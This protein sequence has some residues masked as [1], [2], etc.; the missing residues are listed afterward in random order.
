MMS[1]VIL[2][3]VLVALLAVAVIVLTA[4]VT[5]AIEVGQKALR[6]SHDQRNEGLMVPT[7]FQKITYA[8]L[9]VLLFGVTTGWL[10]GL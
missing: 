8:A 3:L 7:Q 4:A 6:T 9:V 10:G 2:F 1:R 5:R